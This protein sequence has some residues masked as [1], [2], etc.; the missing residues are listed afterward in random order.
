MDALSETAKELEQILRLR[1]QVVAFRRL[2]R[3]DDLGSVQNVRRIDHFSTFCQIPTLVRT[4]G[5]VIGIAKTDVKEGL[6][7]DRCSRMHGLRTASDKSIAAE[8]GSLARTWF[9][10]EEEAIRQGKDCERI[11]AGEAVVLAPLALGL[12]DPDVVLIYGNP[13]QIMMLMCGLQKEAYERLDFT[14]VGEG[15]CSDSA[16]RCYVTGKPSL[17]IPCYGERSFGQVSDDELDIALKPADLDR[18]L[19]GLRKLYSLGLKYPIR[20]RG[21]EQD[22]NEAILARYPE[23]SRSTPD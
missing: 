11:P 14:F 3:A 1:T 23:A 7:L 12:F 16:A 22:L 4:N 2:E 10:S 15:A 19:A 5:W 20:P 6:L 13:A 8:A 17:A 9:G 18:A 21:A